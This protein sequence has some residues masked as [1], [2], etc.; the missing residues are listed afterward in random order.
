[1][2]LRRT[3]TVM[4]YVPAPTIARAPSGP[5]TDRPIDPDNDRASD[6]ALDRAPIGLER[7]VS[8]LP[9]GER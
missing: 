6:R 4:V 5:V 8:A 7:W 1:M 9:E 3:R 2:G